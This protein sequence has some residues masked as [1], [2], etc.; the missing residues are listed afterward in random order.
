M[1]NHRLIEFYESIGHHL[2]TSVTS[3][4]SDRIPHYMLTFHTLKRYIL[5]SISGFDHKE[6]SK[7]ED[8]RKPK[9]SKILSQ[10]SLYIIN[11]TVLV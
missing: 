3:G 4:L 2:G 11:D 9:K 5:G 8:A 1:L 7:Y 6:Y 10:S